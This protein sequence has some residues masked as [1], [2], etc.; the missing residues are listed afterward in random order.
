MKGVFLW[1]LAL[2][3]LFLGCSSPAPQATDS[4][5]PAWDALF[6]TLPDSLSRIA[7]RKMNTFQHHALPPDVAK[8]FR[9]APNEDEDEIFPFG[10]VSID[11]EH[12]AYLVSTNDD[13]D[14]NVWLYVWDKKG[15]RW[16]QPVV[17]LAFQY[18]E[19]ERCEGLVSKLVC[20]PTGPA[21]IFQNESSWFPTLDSIPDEMASE[22][23]RV[24]KWEEGR[25]VE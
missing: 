24:L 9:L 5:A 14:E 4:G 18:C 21:K 11:Q 8:L 22:K 15:A 2:I 19:E 6:E 16:L 7:S 13:G 17:N 3:S 25:F 23:S 12:F 1:M 20:P 10:K